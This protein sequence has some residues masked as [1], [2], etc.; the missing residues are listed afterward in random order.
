MGRKN[1]APNLTPATRLDT[2]R[3]E[4]KRWLKSI[5][6]GDAVA[7]SR[8]AA[9]LPGVPVDPGLRDV[10]LALAREYGLAGWVDLKR[11][12]A[13]LA[14]ARQSVDML[15]ETLLR[16]CWDG[17]DRMAAARILA[18]WPD[19]GAGRFLVDV[20][21][22]DARRVAGHLAADPAL[23]QAKAGPLDWEP[24][25]YLAYARLP[26]SSDAVAVARLLLD[27]GADAGSA[28]DDGWGNRFTALTGVIGQGEGDRPPHPD[29]L[30][31]AHLLIER[32]AS[33]FD[34]Q[35]LYNSSIQRDETDWLTFLWNASD[36][37]G[38]LPLW[39]TVPEKPVIGGS[40]PLNALDYL[41]GNAV[42][43]NHHGRAVWL[44][45]H[46]ADANG[47][48]AYSGRRLT[49]EAL[50]YGHRDMADLLVRYGAPR[51]RLSGALAFQAAVMALDQ[52]QARTLVR[53]HPECLTDP[54]PLHKAAQQGRV[55]VVALLLDLGMPVDLADRTGQRAIQYAVMGNGLDVVRLLL[56]RG[57]DVD[58]PT[59]NYDG[60]MGFAAHFGRYEIAALLAPFSRDVVNLTN[61][62]LTARLHELFQ[63]DPSLADHTDARQGLAP[64]FALPDEE[65]QAAMVTELLLAYGANPARTNAEGETAEQ[66]ARARGLFDAADLM[67]DAM[68]RISSAQNPAPRH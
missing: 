68:D 16:A 25:L 24:L 27:H 61:L 45:D 39:R 7:R 40:V 14:L 10:Q 5:R 36:A 58:T 3:R 50:V 21:R 46:G 33:P 52:D 1:H 41:L 34:T 35:A 67:R 2:L 17:G 65:E 13:D 15:V 11:A 43:Y 66:A 23:A 44:L 22:G 62:G 26:R 49:E 8:L 64:L 59:Q 56:A 54:A 32:G 6:A 29:A 38:R 47:V 57:A 20:I 9:V 12:L 18:R 48:H 55:A 19:L 37:Q 31:L 28:F 51:P 63:E 53:T 60:A 4:A 42:A 30:P